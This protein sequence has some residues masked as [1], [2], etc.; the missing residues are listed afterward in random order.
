MADILSFPHKQPNFGKS[1]ATNSPDADVSQATQPI[2][3]L[4]CGPWSTRKLK[5]PT[6]T[7]GYLVIECFESAEENA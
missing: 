6:S 5:I 1:S 2:E 3:D 4:E 7:S